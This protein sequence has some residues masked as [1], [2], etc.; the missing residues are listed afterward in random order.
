MNRKSI[1]AFT[2]GVACTASL[3][4]L[5][6]SGPEHEEHGNH[7]QDNDMN[8]VTQPEAD[9]MMEM[10]PEDMMAMMNDFSTPG[11]H[12]KLLGKTIGNW[13]ASASFIMDPSAPPMESV[14]S[15]ETKW[16]LDG[17]FTQSVLKMDF[18]GQPFEGHAITGYSNPHSKYVSSWVDTMS[19]HITLMKGNTSEDGSLVMQG[20]SLTPMG[21]N[22]MKI[23]SS[24]IDDNTVQ[25]KF[26]D[27]MPDGTWF[28]SGSITYTR[29]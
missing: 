11:D 23:V 18:M 12:H 3:A 9:E 10:S 1:L 16:I 27:K 20:T 14:G 6:A 24:W 26:Y 13:K 7:D 4:L 15:M 2:A 21:E 8:H 5:I 28:N 17:R 22:P 29:K 19:T 25:D